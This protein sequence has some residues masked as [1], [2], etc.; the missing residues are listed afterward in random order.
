MPGPALRVPSAV[1]WSE[2]PE[3]GEAL[4]QIE[5]S[6]VG[7]TSRRVG[8][9]AHRWLQRIAEDGLD[10]WD[11]QKV[12]SMSKVLRANLA[13]AG[14]GDA[15]LESAAQDLERALVNA[16]EDERGR[17]ILGAHAQAHTEYR[18]THDEGGV[19]RSFVVDRLFTDTDGARW[20][21]DYKTSRH[22]GAGAE[23]F[24]DRE[25]E[26]YR[27]QLQGY[28]GL[29]PGTSRQGLYFPLMPGWRECG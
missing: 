16:L 9:V 1:T 21:V 7:E 13:A 26:R 5:F 23:A 11:A 6:W 2:P 24:L 19:R 17:W 15:D 25:L 22:E 14:L 4:P 18:V 20:I 10:H 27:Q 29:F 8:T 28:A 12:R 3:E